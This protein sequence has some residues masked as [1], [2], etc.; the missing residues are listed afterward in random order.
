M[1]SKT[2]VMHHTVRFGDCDPAGIVFFPNFNRWCDAASLHFFMSNG[3][4]RWTELE[5]THTIIGTP[6]LENHTQFRNSASY[7]DELQIYT[8]VVEWNAK[9]FK[10]QHLVKRGETLICE[11]LET[12]IFCKRLDSGELKSIAIPDF[13]LAACCEA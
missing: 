6:I 8:T 10:M 1:K 4:P 5:R 2:T 9:T 7:P 12:R 13:V 11:S 3:I